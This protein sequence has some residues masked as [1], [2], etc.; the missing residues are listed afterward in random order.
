MPRGES[1]WVNCPMEFEVDVICCFP[2]KYQSFIRIEHFLVYM[3][4][5]KN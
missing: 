1:N 3:Y 5:F 2:V 4:N